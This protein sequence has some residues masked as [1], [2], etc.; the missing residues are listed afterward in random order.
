MV[1]KGL[2]ERIKNRFNVSISEVDNH[3]KW[4]RATLGIASISRDKQFVEMVFNKIMHYIEGEGSVLILDT[5]MEI[6]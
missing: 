2:K 3:D 1:L 5:Q 6:L 4:Q